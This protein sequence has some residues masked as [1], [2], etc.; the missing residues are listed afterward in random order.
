MINLI[1]G[2]NILMAK[3]IKL[4]TKISEY[5]V[6]HKYTHFYLTYKTKD[7]SPNI[8]RAPLEKRQHKR[9]VGKEYE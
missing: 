3:A 9:E 2:K 5:L 6:K 8:Q 1:I 4:K 7:K